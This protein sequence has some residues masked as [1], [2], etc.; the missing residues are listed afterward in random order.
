MKI[1]SQI[2]GIDDVNRTLQDIAPREAKNLLRATVQ[3]LAKALAEDAKKYMSSDEGDME[4]GSKAKRERGSKTS[5]ESTVRNSMFYWRFREYGQG[6]DGV[7]DAMYLNALEAI[8]P[9]LDRVY[10]ETFVKKYE[11]LLARKSKKAAGG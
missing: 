3:D 1:T 7:E 8:R 11:A 6:P 2:T 4:A 10:L 9:D 5:V